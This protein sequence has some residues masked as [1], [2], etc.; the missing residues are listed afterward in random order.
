M[1]MAA[2]AIQGLNRMWKAGYSNPAARGMPIRLYP[3]AQIRFCRIMPIVD[4]ARSIATII[5]GWLRTQEQNV[6]G[7][8]G[9]IGATAHRNSGVSLRKCRRIVDAVANHRNAQTFLLQ[10]ADACE[11]AGRVQPGFNFADAGLV[12]NRRRSRGGVA[13]KHHHAK[14]A[15]LQCGDRLPASGRN[16]SFA[17]KQPID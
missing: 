14:T 10:G 1:A 4:F 7:L 2:A 17:S 11:F 8:L 9:E 3:A 15:L 12:G 16:E 6:S 13:G 5:G